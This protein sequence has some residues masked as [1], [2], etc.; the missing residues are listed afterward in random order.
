MK[1]RYQE[2][3]NTSAVIEL[4]PETEVEQKLIKNFDKQNPDQDTLHYYYQK[5]LELNNVSAVLLRINHF[6]LFPSKA[7]ISFDVVMGF[8][9]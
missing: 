8:G 6:I 4:L 3:S 7:A 9:D 5:G 2:T 1:Y